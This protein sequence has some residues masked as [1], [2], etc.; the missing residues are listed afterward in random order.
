MRS[1]A[2]SLL[3]M[4]VVGC[5]GDDGQGPGPG[6]DG[7]PRGGGP[8]GPGGGR[9]QGPPVAV[10]ATEVITG[11]IAS[12]YTTTATLDA[13]NQ[14]EVLA[15]VSGVIQERRVEE[16]DRVNEG[17]ALLR[18]GDSE[19][20]LRLQEAEA[21]VRRL[22]SRYQRLVSMQENDFV[23]EEEVETARGELE[24]AKARRDLSALEVS[25]TTVTA[26]FAGNVVTRHVDVGQNVSVGTPLFTLADLDRLRAEVHVPSKE[27]RKIQVDQPVTLTLDSTGERLRGLISLVSPVIDPAS[28]TIKVTVEIP[29]VPRGTRPGDFAE[30]QI[31]TDRHEG[32]ILVPRIAVVQDR[33]QHIVYVAAADSTAERRPVTVGFEDDEHSEVLDGLQVG[34]RVV[35]QGQRSLRPGQRLRLLD[36]VRFDGSTATGSGRDTG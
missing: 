27:F 10:A 34:E 24:A 12:H 20:R 21:D 5:G 29:E 28:G 11:A 9:S 32:T 4:I 7:G 22:E 16:G 26:P 30:V 25:Y 17:A 33:E 35:I 1:L 14:A 8:G 36:P 18:I 6:G 23:A 31:V 2:L 15:R 13:R 19:Y 3:A